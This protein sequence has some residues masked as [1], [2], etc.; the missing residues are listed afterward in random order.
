[1][2]CNS[3]TSGVVFLI[4]TVPALNQS[5]RYEK[6]SFQQDSRDLGASHQ[7][8]ID[9]PLAFFMPAILKNVNRFLLVGVCTKEGAVLPPYFKKVPRH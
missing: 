4:D 6:S 1:M 2:L 3:V 7:A 8:H 5:P 9:T